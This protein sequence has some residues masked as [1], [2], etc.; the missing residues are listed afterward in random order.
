MV[1]E[2][3][4]K[5]NQSDFYKDYGN[6]MIE[7]Q[8][9]AKNQDNPFFKSKYVPLKDVLAEAKKVCLSNNFIFIQRPIIRR[10]G[11]ETGIINVLVTELIH[12]TGETKVGEIELVRKDNSDP[13]KL[14]G[15]LTYCRRYSLTAMLGI[16]EEDDDGNK[17]VAPTVVGQCCEDY[18]NCACPQPVEPKGKTKKV[19]NF[20]VPPFKK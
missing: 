2:K 9:L 1:D 10:N 13:Q 11:P 3:K 14:G 4:E 16:Q 15:A 5:S 19:V 17:T 18:P 7:I 12:K 6:L 8:S 20:N